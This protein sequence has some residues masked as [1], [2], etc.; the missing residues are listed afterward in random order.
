MKIRRNYERN[1]LAAATEILENHESSIS[2]A[3]SLSS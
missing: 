2:E 1:T 3:E